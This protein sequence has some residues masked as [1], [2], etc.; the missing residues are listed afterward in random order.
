MS[1]NHSLR[2]KVLDTDSDKEQR[3]FR[4]MEKKMNHMRKENK[5]MV[6]NLK[7]EHKKSID[8]LTNLKN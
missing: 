8:V 2:D 5:A 6:E 4:S 1:E 7:M 3:S